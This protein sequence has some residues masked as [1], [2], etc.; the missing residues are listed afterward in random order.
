MPRPSKGTGGANI[1]SQ[2]RSSSTSKLGANL[3]FT[4]KDL[5]P[6]KHSDKSK[7]PVEVTELLFCQSRILTIKS[8]FSQQKSLPLS[9]ASTPAIN[10]SIP[11]N[12]LLLLLLLLNGNNNH[13]RNPPMEN[14]NQVL[15]SLVMRMTMT[16]GSP[17]KVE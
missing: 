6:Q 13:C 10:G 7:K 4:Q 9:C 1:R 8:F 15:L 5:P 12:N 3:Q 17:V 16:S 11:K 14:P 2:S